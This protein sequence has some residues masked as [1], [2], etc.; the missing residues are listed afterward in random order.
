MK[1]D[2]LYF[3]TKHMVCDVNVV[4]NYLNK[5]FRGNVTLGIFLYN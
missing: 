3:I 1:L 5:Y 2:C 4:K